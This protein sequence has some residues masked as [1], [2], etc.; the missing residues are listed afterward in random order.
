MNRPEPIDATA[1]HLAALRVDMVAVKT[2]LDEL[3]KNV[4]TR[5]DVEA[6]RGEISRMGLRIVMWLV[7]IGVGIVIATK[8]LE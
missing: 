5:A 3:I 8:V 7:G 6:V 1:E 4:A 2:T